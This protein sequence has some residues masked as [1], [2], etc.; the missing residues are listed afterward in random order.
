MAKTILT[1]PEQQADL[2]DIQAKLAALMANAQ[3]DKSKKQLFN[4]I[5]QPLAESLPDVPSEKAPTPLLA[6][7]Q[8]LSAAS[9][10]L[11]EAAYLAE[12][13]QTS[14]LNVPHDGELLLQRGQ[15]TGFY[16]AMQNTIDRINEAEALIDE[17]RKQPEPLPA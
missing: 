5:M 14:S 2:A 7:T 9:E 8:C 17:A 6:S 16:F 1:A 12:F 10:K 15:V 11:S 3:D 4:A 13:I